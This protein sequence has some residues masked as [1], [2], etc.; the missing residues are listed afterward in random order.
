[1]ALIILGLISH[2]VLSS[3]A[4][5]FSKR[6][7]KPTFKF[8]SRLNSD[9]QMSWDRVI[10]DSDEDE[11]LVE[12]EV[13]PTFH[14]LQDPGLPVPRHHDITGPQTN[15]PMKHTAQNVSTEIQL[16]VNFDQFLQSQEGA[17]ASMTL[18]QQRREDRWIPSTGGGGGGSIGA[19]YQSKL[20]IQKHHY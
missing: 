10:Q 13:S 5:V 7:D 6:V 11:P 15:Y 14:Q 12:D 4:C 18:S 2:I 1:M 19:S 16:C 8:L 9:A 20:N 17:Q 3:R